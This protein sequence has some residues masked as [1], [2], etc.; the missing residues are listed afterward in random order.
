MM[1]IPF[2]NLSDLLPTLSK[3]VITS[4]EEVY[5]FIQTTPFFSTCYIEIDDPKKSFIYRVKDDEGY[6]YIRTLGLPFSIEFS[7]KDL[8]HLSFKDTEKVKDDLENLCKDIIKEIKNAYRN[9]CLPEWV[10]TIEDKNFISFYTKEDEDEGLSFLF[11]T[12][13][14]RRKERRA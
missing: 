10:A 3:E 1:A 13:K 2:F 6:V 5:Y 9:N 4:E 14:N 8:K 11:K 7:Q 12:S